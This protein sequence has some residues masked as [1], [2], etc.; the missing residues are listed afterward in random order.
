MKVWFF[1]F[2]ALVL[3]G[4]V[5]L[6][7]RE[8]M[9]CSRP[10]FGPNKNPGVY[11]PGDVP[12]SNSIAG[13]QTSGPR[14]VTFVPNPSEANDPPQSTTPIDVTTGKSMMEDDGKFSSD[15]AHRNPQYVPV[16]QYSPPLERAFPVEEGGP[17]P[18]LT[19]F[20]RIGR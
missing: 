4:T 1:L 6:Q 3:T 13:N 2:L 19:N 12:M 14:R 7:Q 5:L 20:D 17:Q 11:G 9:T 15:T 16:Y 10:L 8:S 18:F